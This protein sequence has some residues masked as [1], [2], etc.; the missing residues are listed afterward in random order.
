MENLIENDVLGFNPQDLDVFKEKPKASG[1]PLVYHTRPAETV[2]KDGV[3]RSTIRIVYNPFDLRTSVLEQQSYAMQDAEGFFTAVSK[4]TNDD[5]DC[6]IFKAWKKCHFA[7]PGT[8]L[9]L[10]AESKDKGGKS[11]FDKRFARYVLIQVMEDANQPDLVGKMMFFKVPKSIW[12]VVNR[13]MNPSSEDKKRTPIPVMDFLFGRAIDIEVNP[14]PDDPQHPERKTREITYSCEIGDIMSITNPDG[15]PILN[16]EESIVAKK[17]IDAMDSGVWREKDPEKRAAATATINADPN[18]GEFRKVYASVLNKIKQFAPN[19][20]KEL[21][22]N[23]WSPELSAR[24]E[25]WINL[26]L[27]CQDPA[28]ASAAPAVAATVGTSV[29]TPV[30]SEPSTAGST[31]T[32]DLPF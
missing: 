19:L 13:Q 26:V 17:Y 21:G 22:Y 20:V 7:Q 23:E 30:V 1:N 29:E 10:Q 32:D 18:T 28:A 31:D 2:S 12:D 6:P 3:Y 15:S 24:V 25:K 4:L 27:A 8:P 9:Y 16:D 5:R 14:G 11:L